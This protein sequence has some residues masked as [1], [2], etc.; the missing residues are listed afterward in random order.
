MHG[1]QRVQA[2]SVDSSGTAGA[3]VIVETVFGVLH[4]DPEQLVRTEGR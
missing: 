1:S 2:E 3:H 4:L